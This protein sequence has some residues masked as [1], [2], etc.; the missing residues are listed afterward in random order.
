MTT[1]QRDHQHSARRAQPDLSMS[2]KAEI[3][4]ILGRQIDR[5]IRSLLADRRVRG[6]WIEDAFW[7]AVYLNDPEI[8]FDRVV[9]L[10]VELVRSGKRVGAALEGWRPQRF[11][12][13]S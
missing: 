12:V 10:V 8:P 9:A 4:E 5:P 13:K 7:D 6:T 3:I 1:H 11:Q 2:K